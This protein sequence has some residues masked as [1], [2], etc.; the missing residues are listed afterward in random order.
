MYLILPLNLISFNVVAMIDAFTHLF[1]EYEKEIK[2]NDVLFYSNSFYTKYIPFQIRSNYVPNLFW[3]S[4]NKNIKSFG[5]ELIVNKNWQDPHWLILNIHSS[6]KE[7]NNENKNDVGKIIVE[8]KG[9]P[10]NAFYVCF[11]LYI[12]DVKNVESKDFYEMK[13]NDKENNLHKHLLDF[14]IL[15]VY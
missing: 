4:E 13:N 9:I 1:I 5:I 12:F 3:E 14:K 2:D 6:I 8:Y 15:T 10:E 7:I 11:I